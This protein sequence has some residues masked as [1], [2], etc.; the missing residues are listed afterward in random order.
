[1]LFRENWSHNAGRTRIYLKQFN[2]V[3]DFLRRNWTTES[4]TDRVK[5]TFLILKTV[6]TACSLHWPSHYNVWKLLKIQFIRALCF[7]C[8]CTRLEWK[9]FGCTMYLLP[10]MVSCEMSSLLWHCIDVTMA[11]SG[12][13]IMGR[14]QPRV[15]TRVSQLPV[16]P[17][18]AECSPLIISTCTDT[19]IRVDTTTA[20]PH[21][22][23]TIH[24]I[25]TGR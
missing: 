4:V 19:N 9:D 10:L 3:S 25:I 22:P 11:V 14:G 20:R 21:P 17:P 6:K 16:R 7:P 12:E 13:L 1:M 23:F 5:Y 24:N 18:G 15:A 8:E 2:V